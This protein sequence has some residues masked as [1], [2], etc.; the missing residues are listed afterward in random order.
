LIADVP[1]GVFLSGG[2]DSSLIAYIA[3]QQTP[4]P[5]KTFTVEYDVGNVGEGSQA[6]QVAREVGA[7]HHEVVLTEAD[8]A[9]DVPALLARLDQPLADQVLVATHAVAQ[10]ARGRVKTVIAGEGADEL[11][12]GYPRYRW[13]HRS[14]RLARLVPEAISAPGS[15]AVRAIPLKARASQLTHVISPLPVLER[16][17]DWMTARRREL[18]PALYGPALRHLVA[19]T[20]RAGDA[21]DEFGHAFHDEDL[22][23]ALMRLDQTHWLPDN[24]L[25][26]ADRAGMFVSLEI[27]SP[28]LNRELAEFAASVPGSTH[29]GRSGKALLRRL[30]AQTPSASAR[31]PKRAFQVPA[32]EWL[33]DPLAPVLTAQVATGR[34]YSEGW[35]DRRA[36]TRMIEEHVRGRRD[37][38][39]ALWPVMALGLWLDRARGSY[40]S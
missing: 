24:I 34:L 35:L 40:G 30:L 14:A 19:G 18:R 26:K 25:A 32:A 12:A 23:G 28:Y 36:V 22:V 27:R 8:V 2:V 33:R 17:L 20:P 7:E 13:L 1:L 16:N 31:R 11:F 9:R 37:W 6:R 39:A 29:V 4:N 38:S 10:F 15:R 3:A 5:I 21:V